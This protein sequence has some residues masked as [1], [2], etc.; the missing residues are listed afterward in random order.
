MVKS[1]KINLLK[2]FL[3]HI[4]SSFVLYLI[5]L[6]ILSVIQGKY[7][8]PLNFVVW[9]FI[10]YIIAFGALQ[11]WIMNKIS[12]I[13]GRMEN[14][15]YALIGVVLGVAGACISLILIPNLWIFSSVLFYGVIC[16]MTYGYL[17]NMH[18]R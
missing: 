7:S 10:T 16:N 15:Y 17:L 3:A 8:S 6:L 11:M 9:V 2:L 5:A 4:I 12:L 13:G 1:K 18:H 14:R